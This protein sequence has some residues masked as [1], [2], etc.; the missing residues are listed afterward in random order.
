MIVT[1]V[2]IRPFVNWVSYDGFYDHHQY[3]DLP[4]GPQ[5]IGGGF[6]IDIIGDTGDDDLPTCGG[7]EITAPDGSTYI[8]PPGFT[9]VTGGTGPDA[10]HHY[11]RGPDGTI[12]MTPYGAS[13]ATAA[14]A[15]NSG[16]IDSLSS[17][18]TIGTEVGAVTGAGA[19]LSVLPSIGSGLAAYTAALLALPAAVLVA[20]GLIPPLPDSINGPPTPPT[21]PDE[22]G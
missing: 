20:L 16:V 7:T 10:G 14:Y 15:T 17:G 8:L 12:Y 22:D 21:C 5:E 3:F 11:M 6:D 9:P 18:V 13:I 19:G 4:L 1:G 2:I